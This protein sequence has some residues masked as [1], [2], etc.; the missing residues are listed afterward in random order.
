MRQA[1][2]VIWA[3][4]FA[5]GAGLALT[6]TYEVVIWGASGV[7]SFAQSKG[8]AQLKEKTIGFTNGLFQTK[9]TKGVQ[10]KRNI[11]VTSAAL[12]LDEWIM[13]GTVAARKDGAAIITTFW[14][15]DYGWGFKPLWNDGETYFR[16]KQLTWD[17]PFAPDSNVNLPWIEIC[18]SPVKGKAS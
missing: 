5:F 10:W 8:V 13:V 2:T 14:K 12:A 3:I 11:H 7:T 16:C 9:I 17:L 1:I 15:K 6:L 4:V 18:E